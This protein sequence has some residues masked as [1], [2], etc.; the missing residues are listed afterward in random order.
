[1]PG[2]N[3]PYTLLSADQVIQQSFDESQ[4][5]L[6]VD[7]E[8]T[9]VIG[10]IEVILTDDNDAIK[11]GNG[12][13]VYANVDSGRN[14]TTIDVAANTKLA[15]IDS[16]L[17]T[18][19]AVTQSTSP[20]IV[21]GTVTSNQ[22]TSPWVISGNTGRTWTLS[23]STDSISAVQSGIWT[24]ARSWTLSSGTDS[25]TIT[26][27]VNVGN[28]PAT[29]SVTQGTSPWVVSQS[30]TWNIG[31]LSTITNVVHIDD[32][33]GSITV[34]GTVTANQGTS[35]WV[36]SGTVTTSLSNDTNYGTV[37]ANTLR[38]AAQIGNATGSALFGAG[39]TTAQVLRVV[40]PTDQTSIP[41]TQSGTWN[42]TNVSGTV[43]LPT[44]ASTSALQTTGNTSL[45][46]IDGK[47]VADTTIA[48]GTLINN[49]DTFDITCSGQS[50]LVAHIGIN[51]VGSFTGTVNFFGS[52]NGIDYQTVF[53]S[54]ITNLDGQLNPS[55][56]TES[57]M[58]FNIA[59]F[60][61]FKLVYLGTTD[62]IAC[63]IRTAKDSGVVQQIQATTYVNAAQYGIW[64]GV[65]VTDSG[66]SLT[67]DNAGTFA[68][69]AAQS[70]TWNI[71]N[72]SGTISLPTGASTSALQTTGNTSLASI[73]TKLARLVSSSNA[74]V[75]ALA[76]N[77]TMLATNTNRK[78]FSL[79]NDSTSI[80][81]VK[82]GSTA[83]PTSYTIQMGPLDYYESPPLM[84]WVGQVDAIWVS[85][86]G[87]MYI[88]E[89]T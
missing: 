83:D 40:L 46:S 4:D 42:I 23:N 76:T 56:D 25:V 38:S 60:T 49:N 45:S 48:S 58:A 51:H 2:P 8:V 7:A 68:T 33:G 80:C 74:S 71:T 16:K 14:L 36:I 82:F 15:S 5:R 10:T 50:G 26:G 81:Y 73:D 18:G 35:P 44:G 37:G 21:S 87:N 20:W 69:Q 57:I 55:V 19:I 31:T 27:T 28:F 11:I 29:Q 52:V 75:S 3:V 62:S 1:M 53:G 89:L 6:R 84:C 67:V 41:V 22:G 78:A 12:A 24:T 61:K 70:G 79:T 34:D 65:G 32:N 77:R 54:N 13:H 43:S 59:G 63:Y 17:S 47:L 85:A 30:G 9:A 39:T 66:G 86:T 64:T 88:T 72:I